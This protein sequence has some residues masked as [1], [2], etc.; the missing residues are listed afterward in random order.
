MTSSVPWKERLSA[1]TEAVQDDV[2]GWYQDTREG[3]AYVPTMVWGTLQTEAYATVI[4]RQVVDFLGV[5]D[6]VPAGVAK[7][8]RRQ[9]VLHDSDH[10]YDV[11]LGEQ[12]LYTNVGGPDVMGA[13]IDRLLRDIDLPSLSLGILPA[14]APVDMF[15]VHAFNI[16]GHP[17]R[18][19]VELVSSTVDVTEQ[20]ELDLYR[21]AF[22]LLRR[23]AVYEDAAKELL[24]KARSFWTRA[25]LRTGG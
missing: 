18:A 7:R 9:E 13:Q 1:G 17:D 23:G 10:H 5:P 12:A 19:H 16:Y 11:I 4:L 22:D 15:P 6:D 2:I 21:K 20:G 8:M 3:L 14:A 25:P 24:R